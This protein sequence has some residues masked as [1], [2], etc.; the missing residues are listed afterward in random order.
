[1]TEQKNL[2]EE[3]PETMT[4]EEFKWA[5]EVKGLCCSNCFSDYTESCFAT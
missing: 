2:T 4:E 3:E 5:A 1:M